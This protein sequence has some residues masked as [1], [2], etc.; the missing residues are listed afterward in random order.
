[1]SLV[2]QMYNFQQLRRILG[3]TITQIYHP[4]LRRNSFSF[5]G[6]LNSLNIAV[7][8]PTCQYFWR[9]GKNLSR[10]KVGLHFADCSQFEFRR[11]AMKAEGNLQDVFFILHWSGSAHMFLLQAL[12]CWRCGTEQSVSVTMKQNPTQLTQKHNKIQHK[13]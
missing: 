7:Y 8:L 12:G 6:K 9:M 11:Y 2:F 13:I 1:M 3:S 4:K 10:R 5:F